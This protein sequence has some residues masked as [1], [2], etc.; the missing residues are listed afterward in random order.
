MCSPTQDPVNDH[1]SGGSP[2]SRSGGTTSSSRWLL[3]PTE[4]SA[5]LFGRM[6]GDY[7]HL[8]VGSFE[9]E[10]EYPADPVLRVRGHWRSTQIIANW[11]SEALYRPC[12]RRG[13]AQ[14]G[15]ARRPAETWLLDLLN[16]V[17]NFGFV[18]LGPSRWYMGGECLP[19]RHGTRPASG[20]IQTPTG[21]SSPGSPPNST[22][23]DPTELSTSAGRSPTRG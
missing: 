10:L 22:R 13:A 20:T 16:D 18:Q 21:C 3:T 7:E 15:R 11:C 2:T 1:R 9:R 8:P 17:A 5:A 6:I 19:H 4:R 12:G 23:R 14:R